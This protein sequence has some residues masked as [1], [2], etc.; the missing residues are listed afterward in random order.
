MPM[1]ERTTPR[2]PA[3]AKARMAR[4]KRL[5]IGLTLAAV[6]ALA[7]GGLVCFRPERATEPSR[8]PA[9]RT[10]LEDLEA[11]L[12]E[13]RSAWRPEDH[14]RVLAAAAE[15]TDRYAV[16]LRRLFNTPEHPLVVPGLELAGFLK[17]QE[18]L[19]LVLQLAERRELR[20]QAMTAAD[21]IAP[22]SDADLAGLLD[23]PD[24]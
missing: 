10:G 1:R 23:D 20:L 24:P 18:V 2:S 4:T 11:V 12:V 5:R 13:L 16:A 14:E 21:A 15:H 7:I 8:P 22:L 17:L 6:G 3:D 19:P 9:S